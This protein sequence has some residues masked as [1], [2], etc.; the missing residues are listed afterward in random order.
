[1]I[2]TEKQTAT[3]SEIGRTQLKRIIGAALGII[4]GL[5][6]ALSSP[7]PGLEANAMQVL[8]ITTFA[9]IFWAFGVIPDMITALLMNVLFVLI[10]KIPFATAFG[11]FSNSALWLVLAA[12]LFSAA[13]N[14]TGLIRRFSLWMLKVL[15]GT[16]FG[17]LLGLYLTGFVV[18]GPMVPS[19]VAKVSIPTPFA[20]G[21]A[22]SMGLEDGSRGAAGLSLGVFISSAVL[23]GI[24]FMTGMAPNI[25]YIGALSADVKQQITWSGWLAAGLPIALL[26]GIVMFLILWLYFG[27][28][29]E[30]VSKEQVYSQLAELGPMTTKEKVSGVIILATFILWIMGSYIGVGATEAALVA[31]AALF[32]ANIVSNK[33]LAGVSWS[34]WIY[35]GLILNIGADMTQVGVDKWLNTILGPLLVPLINNTLVFVMALTLVITVIRLIIP[36]QVTSGVLILVVLAPILANI[37]FNPFIVVIIMAAVSNHW[38]M[39]YLNV[40]Y[41]AQ[42]SMLDGKGHTHVQARILSVIYL[43]LCLIGIIMSL[44]LWKMLGLF[45]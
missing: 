19:A 4:V 12:M 34:V 38:L 11:G 1:M 45:N 43:G 23:G 36:S 30:A 31:M 13:L 27:K 2:K 21:V 44:P 24:A 15:P 17:Q 42:Y 18:I 41:L 32:L 7:F 8:G 9:V 40:P 22:R 39:P 29:V 37:G 25:A 28:G 10:V 14:S 20:L 26:I 6:I 16:Y 3:N 33:D 5:W 35:L